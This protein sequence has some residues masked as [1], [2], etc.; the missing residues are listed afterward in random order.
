MHVLK[1]VPKVVAA[2]ALAGSVLVAVPAHASTAYTPEGV[3]GAGFARVADGAKPVKDGKDTYGYVYLMY[4]RRT[5]YNCV[6]TIKT[7]YYRT[8]TYTTAMLRVQGSKPVTDAG[9]FKYYAGPVKLKAAG[10]CV[11]YWG[12]IRNTRIDFAE[13]KGGRATFGN[14][15]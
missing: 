1:F 5:G 8:P 2:A 6:V 15:K 9:K 3:C 7:S 13:A 11:A 4:N 12:T 14:C 10:K